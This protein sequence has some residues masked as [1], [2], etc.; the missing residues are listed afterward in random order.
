VA[1][2]VPRDQNSGR[3]P[4]L[5]DF[6]GKDSSR[7]S[8]I[9]TSKP[10]VSS[11]EV[12]PYVKMPGD[13]SR[14]FFIDSSGRE[15]QRI[16]QFTRT[17]DIA[18]I[19]TAS[20]GGIPDRL[21]K[22]QAEA[23]WG[24][25]PAQTREAITNLAKAID[26]RKTGASLWREAVASSF[27]TSKSG[28]ARSPYDVLNQMAGSLSGEGGTGGTGGRSGGR[29]AAYTGPVES[30]TVQAESDVRAT[31]DAV[32]M[33]MLGRG[34]SDEEFKRIL[35]RTRKAEQAQP[36]VDTSSTGRRV[37]EQGLTAEGRQ[38]I[39]QNIIAKKPE[40][41]EFQKATTLMSWFD[42]ALQG[43]MQQ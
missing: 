2:R 40:Y 30:I 18:G 22:A 4:S 14:G 35:N 37:T 27:E 19:T 36:Q 21:T 17:T 28:D 7:G 26:Y 25:L 3:P 1:P 11:Y 38:D 23:A 10:P 29:A 41:E 16:P 31:A 9:D 13:P 42:R 39:V 34:V 33:E 8:T 32:A 15:T 12:K 43:R 20:T 5:D 24:N 6:P